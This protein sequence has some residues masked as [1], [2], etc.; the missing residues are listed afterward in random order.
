MP[1]Q[2]DLKLPLE[3]PWKLASTTQALQAGGP[4]DVSVSVFFFEPSNEN[5]TSNF[6]DE[7]LVFLKFAV[8]VSPSRLAIGDRSL[9][10]GFLGEDLPVL[11]LLLDLKVK[12]GSGETGGIRSYFH[13]AAPLNRRLLQT[14]VIG[15]DAFEG[16]ASGQSFGK[17]GSHLYE[18]LN[19]HSR[20]NSNHSHQQGLL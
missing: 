19:T 7:K 12:P 18:S 4:N 8:S 15:D 10:L 2:E 5:L 3:V 6:P 1:D 17:T 9:A 20:T 16:E 13:A 11:H 14:G